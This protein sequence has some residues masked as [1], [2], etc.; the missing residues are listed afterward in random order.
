MQRNR[1]N[2]YIAYRKTFPHHLN[3]DRSKFDG[4]VQ[5]AKHQDEEGLLN[6]EE[7]IELN[8]FEDVSYTDNYTGIIQNIE[9]QGNDLTQRIKDN[10]KQL[11][12]RYKEVLLPQFD[13]EFVR[14][15]MNSI[16]TLSNSITDELRMIYKVI[17]D[18]QQLDSVL[19]SKE[20]EIKSPAFHD[21][22]NSNIKG[23][24]I[25]ISNLKKKFAIV[26][27]ELSGE[28]REMQGRYI[29]Y[30]KKDESQINDN[31]DFNE[32]IESYS[33]N[34]MVESGKQIETQIQLKKSDLLDDQQYLL[35]RERGIY[36]ISQ[37]VIEISII[38]KELENI[39]IDQGTILDNIE[40]NIDRTVENVEGAHKQLIRAEGYQKQTRKCKVIFF[41]VLLIIASLLLLMVK[42]RRV[43]HYVHDTPDKVEVDGTES[44]EM[45]T[46]VTD[47]NIF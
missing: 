23:T 1:T 46:I 17:N 15:E 44:A 3:S 29:R 40:Y 13:D 34:A 24:R 28:F 11:S 5:R 21:D 7:G 9:N 6:L 45:D 39:V 4:K 35:E 10:M 8:E 22:S 41:L 37:S 47:T 31:S 33:R 43:T 14:S 20:M 19:I 26:S 16:N 36:K 32:D 18:L 30:L 2:L 42:P 27:Q 12:L 25:L 38:F